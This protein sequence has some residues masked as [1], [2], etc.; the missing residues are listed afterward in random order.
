VLATIRFDGS[1][2]TALTRGDTLHPLLAYHFLSGLWIQVPL[3]VFH[4]SSFSDCLA[5]A[6]A[7]ASWCPLLPL[8]YAE[9]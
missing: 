2:M 1:N 4:V 6:V 5:S 7:P 3:F 9:F 8:P